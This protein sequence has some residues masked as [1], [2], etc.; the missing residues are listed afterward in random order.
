MDTT[1]NALNWFEIPAN[2]INRSKKFYE[3]IFDIKMDEFEM[4][5]TKMAFFPMAPGSGKAAGA[6]AQGPM[7][8]T[9]M[10]GALVYLNANPNMDVVLERVEASGGKVLQAKT[11]IGE[12]GFMA[13]IK[14]TEG[15]NV[16][17][18]SIE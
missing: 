5:G 7:H 9:S 13:F 2:D 3:T 4:N 18:H 12:N 6:L 17:I 14:D 8:K 11:G 1:T 15:N 16:G 10:E